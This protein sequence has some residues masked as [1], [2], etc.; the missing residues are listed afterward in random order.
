MESDMGELSDCFTKILDSALDKG[1]ELPFYFAIVG[2]NGKVMF[3]ELTWEGQDLV[4]K[5]LSSNAADS[6]LAV[7]INIMITDQ[8]GRAARVLIEKSQLPRYFW[9]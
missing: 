2:R 3:Y 7:P 1:F 6:G 8:A 5:L 9:N 4:P